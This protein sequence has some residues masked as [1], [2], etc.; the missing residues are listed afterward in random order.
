MNEEEK[1]AQ[2]ARAFLVEARADYEAV[3][4]L[5]QIGRYNLAIYHAQQAVEKLLKACLTL[6][7]KIGIY[8]HEVFS[9][10]RETF[11]GRMAEELLTELEDDV[12]E[13]EEEWAMSRYPRWDDQ[14]LWIPSEAYTEQ[15]ALD[16]KARMERI[17]SR[18]GQFLEHE[19]HLDLAGHPLPPD[20]GQERA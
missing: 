2:V 4:A 13:L 19:Y 7:G 10:F 18:I 5:I 15:D 8:K 11:A 17:F 1:L 20:K 16:R 14:S 6:E 3:T 12:V 9:F